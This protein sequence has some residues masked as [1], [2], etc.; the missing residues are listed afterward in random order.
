MDWKYKTS[1]ESH[2]CLS[3]GGRCY[4]P[5]GKN[6]GGCTVH[7]GMAYHRGHVKDYSR[8]VEKG[9]KGWSWE[10]VRYTLIDVLRRAK[11]M[12]RQKGFCNVQATFF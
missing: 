6:L 9:N 5:R 2:A 4:W 10:E 1:N 11:L 12:Q 8:W 3:T 7:H